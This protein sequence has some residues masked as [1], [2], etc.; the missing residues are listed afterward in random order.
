MNCPK[1]RDGQFLQVKGAGIEVLHVKPAEDGDGIVVRLLNL[2]LTPFEAELTCPGRQVASAWL[3]GAVEQNRERLTVQNS[4]VR[5]PL[6]SRRPTTIR[7][8]F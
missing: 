5:C 3:T 7:V 6:P 2:G 1:P 4:T 8:R